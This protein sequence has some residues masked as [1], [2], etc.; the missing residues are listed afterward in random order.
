M[1]A[2]L[3][4]DL[5]G[6][7]VT[8]LCDAVFDP[9]AC[10]DRW[11]ADVTAAISQPAAELPLIND[12]LDQA[13]FV[14]SRIGS[15]CDLN[16]E[17]VLHFDGY[18]LGNV[19]SPSGTLV[20]TRRGRIEADINVGVAII[21]G[22]VTGNITAS[23]RVVLE[24]DARVKGQIFTRALSMRLG[25]ILDGDCLLVGEESEATVPYYRPIELQVEDPG[26]AADLSLVPADE[27]DEELEEF[28][29]S[30]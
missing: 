4:R 3:E 19:L 27:A 8:D 14:E 2:L 9:A 26:P 28:L 20:L 12:E 13:I 24:S 23:E 5:A 25:A 1:S 22:T 30:A 6:D 7:E 16:F 15:N 29:L 18:S 21:G 17:G 10:F 11:L